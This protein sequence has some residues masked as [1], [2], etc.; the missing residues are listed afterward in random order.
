MLLCSVPPR[1][2]AEL[3]NLNGQVAPELGRF[4]QVGG[5][6]R[7][8]SVAA[9]KGRAVLLVFFESSYAACDR[10]AP[11]LDEVFKQYRDRG[12][13]LIAVSGE[14]TD[15]VEAFVE[16]HKTSFPVLSAP[17][18]LRNY[19]ID[20]YPTKYLVAPSGKVVASE[21]TN[22]T[23]TMIE[24]ALVTAVAYPLL[25]YSKKFDP[26]LAHLKAKDLVRAS[27]ELTKLEKEDGKD[28]EHARVL[29]GWIEELGQKRIA[30]ADAARD[31]G[32]VFEARDLLASIDREFPPKYE[33]TK[34]SKEKLRELREDKD[35]KKVLAAENDWKLAQNAER[36]KNL[37]KAASLY[38]KCAKATAGTKFAE[39]CEARAKELQPKK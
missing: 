25:D 4:E 12:L 26:C 34:Q 3:K 22:V 14:P 28:G 16:K 6:D 8:E 36:E 38:M 17:L 23:A 1:V 35:T 31:Q 7:V 29:I 15:K 5:M 33:C 18:A 19:A 30:Q 27:T 2:W 39:R 11:K 21:N 13:M 32:E 24:E 20:G 9:L 10:E 37:S